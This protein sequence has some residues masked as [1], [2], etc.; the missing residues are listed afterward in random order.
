MFGI[1][2]PALRLHHANGLIVEECP[3]EQDPG[4]SAPAPG[5]PGMGTEVPGGAHAVLRAAARF[6][7]AMQTKGKPMNVMPIDFGKTQGGAK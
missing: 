6:F 7:S 4:L 2:G 5:G 3:T 1:I